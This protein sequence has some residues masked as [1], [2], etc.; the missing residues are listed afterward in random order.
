MENFWQTDKQSSGL[1]SEQTAAQS[2][3]SNFQWS[4]WQKVQF[5]TDLLKWKHSYLYRKWWRWLNPK[6]LITLKENVGWGLGKLKGE[7]LIELVVL[8]CITVRQNIELIIIRSF[9]KLV[10]QLYSKVMPVFYLTWAFFMCILPFLK[11]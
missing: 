6:P 1:T 9:Y 7:N 4:N 5:D 11:Y 3:G 10:N 2:S 8:I